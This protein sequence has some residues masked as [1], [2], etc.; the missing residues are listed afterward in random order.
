MLLVHLKHHGTVGQKTQ[1][2]SSPIL[3]TPH[4]DPW[5]S[6]AGDWGTGDLGLAAV[7]GETEQ[8]RALKNA[9]ILGEREGALQPAASRAVVEA[10]DTAHAAHRGN[11]LKVPKPKSVGERTW[12]HEGP[13]RRGCW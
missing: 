7:P 5:H 13:C 4:T 2:S 12:G 3:Q 10:W 6:G 9:L 1:V 11:G 8:G